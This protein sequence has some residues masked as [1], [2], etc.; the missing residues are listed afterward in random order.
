[1]CNVQGEVCN[2]R[3]PLIPGY[4]VVG[5]RKSARES[6]PPARESYIILA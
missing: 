5:A 4:L 2:G 1:V 3:F 6:A